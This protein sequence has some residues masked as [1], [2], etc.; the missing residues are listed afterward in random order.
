MF[1]AIERKRDSFRTTEEIPGGSQNLHAN[2]IDK[3]DLFA[4]N[5][6]IANCLRSD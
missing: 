6:M 1:S 3:D 5:G 2:L 4:A